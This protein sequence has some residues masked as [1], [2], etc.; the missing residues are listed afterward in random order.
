MNNFI[1]KLVI[2]S[3][4]I[5]LWQI[6][7]SGHSKDYYWRKKEFNSLENFVAFKTDYNIHLM[8]IRKIFQMLRESYSDS[9]TEGIFEKFFKRGTYASLK[10]NQK[11]IQSE[12]ESDLI[13]R[14]EAFFLSDE[15]LQLKE[16]F[17]K[18]RKAAA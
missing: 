5:S 13:E 12:I 9:K 8:A 10:R 15:F 16:K 14:R 17:E 18:N 4:E 3:K 7:K 11:Q 6:D 1:P 2:N